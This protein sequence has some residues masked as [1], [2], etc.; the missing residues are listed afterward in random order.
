MWEFKRQNTFGAA[1]FTS[2]GAFWMGF[3]LL[4]ILVAVSQGGGAAGEAGWCLAAGQ[5]PYLHRSRPLTPFSPCLPQ[6]GLFTVGA[7]ADQMFLS[8]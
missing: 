7:N 3:A 1:A 4:Q 5:H 6:A 8:L 2:Y